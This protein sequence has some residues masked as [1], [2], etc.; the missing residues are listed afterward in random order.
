MGGKEVN[1][2]NGTPLWMPKGT[3][4]AILALMVVGTVCYTFLRQVEVPER[5]IDLGLLVLGAYF[6][7]KV[8]AAMKPEV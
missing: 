5:L 8:I 2:N 1:N 4:R 6:V 7:Q 3:I